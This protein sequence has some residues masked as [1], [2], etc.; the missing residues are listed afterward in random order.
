M[1][2]E[3]LKKTI[4]SI[5]EGSLELTEPISVLMI[6]APTGK[7]GKM[8]VTEGVLKGIVNDNE[9][10]QLIVQESMIY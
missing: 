1:N 9:G 3:E 7:A 4:D 10:F 8:F 2:L 6:N 5:E